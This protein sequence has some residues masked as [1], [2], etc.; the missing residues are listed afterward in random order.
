M[1]WKEIREMYPNKFVKLEILESHVNNGKEYVD[2]VALIKVISDGK[3]AMKEFLKCKG[4]QVVYSTSNK[5]FV[6]E[7]VK[8]VGIRRKS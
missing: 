3:K 6:I 1:K 8:N 2:E 4:K 7:V 5:E